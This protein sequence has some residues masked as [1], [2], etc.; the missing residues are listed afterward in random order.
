MKRIKLIVES[1]DSNVELPESMREDLR[2]IVDDD[3]GAYLRT[4]GGGYHLSII[5]FEEEDE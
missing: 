2:V 3:E 5:G 4:A 1:F